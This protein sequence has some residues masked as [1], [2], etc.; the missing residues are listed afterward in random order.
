MSDWQSE[1]QGF[2]SP[3]LHQEKSARILGPSFFKICVENFLKICYN[4]KHN[5][6]LQLH[7][8]EAEVNWI[9]RIGR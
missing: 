3:K 4:K 6:Y 8:K 7:K 9:I 2:E 5:N 1:G